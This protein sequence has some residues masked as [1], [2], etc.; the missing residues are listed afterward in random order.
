MDFFL[1]PELCTQTPTHKLHLGVQ[2]ASQSENSQNTLILLIS[3]LSAHTDLFNQW[4]IKGGVVGAAF[5][6]YSVLNTNRIRTL[7][8]LLLKTSL[9]EV[10]LYKNNNNNK[11]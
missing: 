6:R 5:P 9:T 4:H 1:V 3:N 10:P 11:Y 8:C 7:A 2:N